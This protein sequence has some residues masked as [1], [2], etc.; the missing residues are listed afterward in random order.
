MATKRNPV[1]L[2]FQDCET[3]S[4]GLYGR[5]IC[6]QYNLWNITYETQ[7]IIET[8]YT[9]GYDCYIDLFDA[10]L[11]TL[12]KKCKLFLIYFNASFDIQ[13]MIEGMPS[14]IFHINLIHSKSLTTRIIFVDYPD[15]DIEIR[16]LMLI[17]PTSLAKFTES[18]APHIQKIKRTLSFEQKPFDI[19]DKA[20]I[21]YAIRDV[22]SMTA[23]FFECAAQMNFKIS[24]PPLTTPALAMKKQKEFYRASYSTEWRGLP[25][26][27]NLQHLKYCHGGRNLIG[28]GLELNREI[29][30]SCMDLVSA[31]VDK[32]TS[33]YYPKAAQ[34]P[35]VIKKAPTLQSDKARFLITIKVTDYY[36][37][38]YSM[39]PTDKGI[40]ASGTFVSH[41]TDNEYFCLLKYH[42]NFYKKLEVLEVHYWNSSQCAQ[43]LKNYSEFYFKLKEKGDELNVKNNGQGEAMR[44]VGKLMGNSMFGKFIQKYYDKK[45]VFVVS[46]DSET[47]TYIDDNETPDEPKNEQSNKN[48]HRFYA[49]GAMITGS[50]RAELYHC[51]EHYGS[52]NLL[53]GDT[54]SLKFKK[55]IETMKPY[56]RIGKQ[57]GFFKPEYVSDNTRIIIHAP[58][59]YI[60]LT[61][62]NGI[63]ERKIIVKGIV[64]RGSLQGD[65]KLDDDLH[66]A[67]LHNHELVVKYKT[68][69]NTLKRYIN[70]K[71]LSYTLER[72][73]TSR[74]KVRGYV[75]NEK[76][77]SY[78]L[79]TIRVHEH[80]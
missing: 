11:P 57:L 73:L 35:T 15:I 39:L 40:Y 5:A 53:N 78:N 34:K 48:D 43:I 28:A 31:Y 26:E 54:D 30:A 47:T 58:K 55:A 66:N 79:P 23:A 19:N 36:P 44:T 37:Q 13:R 68:S 72:S 42:S 64:R 3:D 29:E 49:I 17:S 27:I 1:F 67:M 62:K 9:T 76:T 74:D 60:M 4:D 65:K 24:E 12:P 75:W 25:K 69:A 70:D 45:D 52:E 41:I 63:E 80:E 32:M 61:T 8:T 2:S 10:L 21:D 18:F 51:I 56:K 59:C 6:A 20:D 33:D 77:K 7:Q 50:I 22:D 14:N 46:R 16:D 38:H 71:S